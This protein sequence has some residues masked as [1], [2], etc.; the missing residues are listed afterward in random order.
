MTVYLM[1]FKNLFFVFVVVFCFSLKPK[2]LKYQ[3]KSLRFEVTPTVMLT[4][5]RQSLGL[6]Y[7]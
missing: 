4:E 6:L 7:Y 1:I 2:V 3:H 5:Y